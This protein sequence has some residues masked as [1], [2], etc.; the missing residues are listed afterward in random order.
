MVANALA[1][2]V[3][4]LVPENNWLTPMFEIPKKVCRVWSTY[5]D[6]R[7][8]GNR[9]IGLQDNICRWFPIRFGGLKETLGKQFDQ[10]YVLVKT[11]TEFES[12]WLEHGYVKD[13]E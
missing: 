10:Y 6:P 11:D 13:W 1:D 12:K 5:P 8:L 3:V 4:A 2:K 7:S 9:I